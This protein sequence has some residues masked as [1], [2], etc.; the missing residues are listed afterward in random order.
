M[1]TAAWLEQTETYLPAFNFDSLGHSFSANR[2]VG[3][4]TKLARQLF[5][6]LLLSDINAKESRRWQYLGRTYLRSRITF[7]VAQ[8]HAKASSRS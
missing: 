4:A 6:R 2:K 8:H 7:L 1:K 3:F 5:I